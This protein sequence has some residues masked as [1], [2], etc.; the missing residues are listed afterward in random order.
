M[1]SRLPTDSWVPASAGKYPGSPRPARQ[2]W[3]CRAAEPRLHPDP[4][5]TAQST[6]PGRAS[7]P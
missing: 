1:I 4:Q 6:R 5:T 7:L 2:S 3:G